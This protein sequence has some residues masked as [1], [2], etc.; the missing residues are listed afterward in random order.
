[1][2]RLTSLVPLSGLIFAERAGAVLATLAVVFL[3]FFAGYLYDRIRETD[4]RPLGVVAPV[5][6]SMAGVGLLVSASTTWVLTDG[7]THYSP[8]GAQVINALGY[9]AVLPI[10]AG[11]IVFAIATRIAV[12]RERWSGSQA[13]L[14]PHRVR[15][16]LGEPIVRRR[17]GRGG[18]L[19]RGRGGARHR[20]LASTATRARQP[21]RRS[22]MMRF[23]LATVV[24][25]VGAAA[26]ALPAMALGMA[27]P[28]QFT[29]TGQQQV[30][31]VPS[32]VLLEGVVA[33]GGWGG[34]TDPQPP[35]LQGIFAEGATLQGYLATRPGQTLYAEVGQSGT[36][37]GGSTFGGGGAAGAPPP[38]VPNCTLAGSDMSVPCSGPWAGS[39]GGASDIRTCS[40]LAASCSGGVTSAASRLIVAAGGGGEGGG[41]L[42]GNGAGC[43]NPGYK[44]G[45]GQNYQLPTASLS[46]PAAINT[47]AGI[48]VPGFAGGAEAS[49]M[50]VDGSTNAAMGTTAAGAG[51][52]RTGCTVGT[53]P[54]TVFYSGS[55]AGTAGSASNGGAGGNASGLG[56][57]CGSPSFA[58]GGGGGG[59]GGYLGGGGGATGMGTCS[60][61]NGNGGTGAGGAAGSSFASN[62]IEYPEVVQA[63]NTGD[64]FIEFVPVIEI[65]TPAN[66]AVYSPGQVV[67][68]NWSC[69]Y[70][71]S[72]ALGCSSGTTG[73]VP[74]G[75]PINTTPGTHTFTVQSTV[76]NSGG[77][78]PISA[79]VT[80]TVKAGGGKPAAA[81]IT[82]AVISSRHHRAKFKFKST[83][84]GATGFQCALSKKPKDEHNK[85]KPRY[86]SCTSPETYKHLK[87]GHYTFL[88]RVVSGGIAGTAASKRFKIS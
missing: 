78:H 28:T 33:V 35:A 77:S 59:G 45:E 68:A 50:T 75:S 88:V 8:S 6:A 39:G 85:A 4:S 17:P 12:L 58:P 76:N 15:A 57:C 40:E 24:A 47:D 63:Y 56:P 72:T 49:V 1:M 41:G 73:T 13:G 14:D 36:A 62:S 86:R 38:G 79:T 84:A 83:A 32:G 7:P 87:A 18:R 5:G 43:D 3:V 31:T 82:K 70:S 2:N 67:D 37:G 10:I 48:V 27:A 66:G 53:P 55:V 74:S 80:Y 46:G 21:G 52:V 61:C 69:G 64:V 60:G 71:S 9:D 42:G 23:R 81:K 51:G 54:N 30:Y 44:G 11:L 34:S 20:S 22:G 16:H 29:P 19:E 25:L 26:L 65:D